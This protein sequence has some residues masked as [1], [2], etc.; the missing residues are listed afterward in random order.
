MV[1]VQGNTF[2]NAVDQA[3]LFA[4]CCYV[5]DQH[6]VLIDGGRLIKPEQFKSFFGGYQFAIDATGAKTTDN[7]FQALT[8]SRVLRA[9]RVDGTCFRPD[10]PY[11][12]IIRTEGRSRVNMFTNANVIRTPGDVTPALKHLGLILPKQ[13]DG[14]ALLYY[15]AGCVQ[16]MGRKFQWF[17]LLIGVEG[18]GKSFFSRCLAYACGKRYT[19][20]PDAGKLGK[21]FNGWLFG[22]VLICIEDLNI[23]DADDTWEKLKPMITGE[24]L[25]I[26]AKGVDQRTDEICANFIANSNHKSA[27]RATKNDRRVSHLWCAQQ[28]LADLERDGMME[29]YMRNL[30]KW[31]RAGGYAAFAHYLATLDIP[32]EYGLDWLTGRAPHTSSTDLAINAARGGVEQEILDAVER[33]EIGFRGDWISS[34]YLDDLLRRTGKDRALHINRR[35]DVLSALG[36]LWHPALKEGRVN[37]VVEPDG[38]KSK[39]FVK[40]G[41]A[42]AAIEGAAAAAE[43]YTKANGVQFAPTPVAAR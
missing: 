19:H 10:L 37:N 31:A 4:G 21:D 23:G 26:E 40:A 7:A 34:K 32:P 12:S 8:E 27:H 20:W 9:P 42:T 6:R 43:A 1:A 17:P 18:N 14:K 41:S 33:E 28:E 25:E 24:E 30:Y 29:D 39:L 16:Y 2:L 11:G 35:R 36:Y 38:V 22:K 15:M 5:L 13:Q 3:H